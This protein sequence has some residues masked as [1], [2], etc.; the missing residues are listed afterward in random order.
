MAYERGRGNDEMAL[1]PL[2][3]PLNVGPERAIGQVRTGKEVVLL[4]R[5][6]SLLPGLLE[7]LSAE[8]EDVESQKQ[9]SSSRHRTIGSS[10]LSQSQDQS[11]GHGRTAGGGS[12][13][14]A[15]RGIMT[16]RF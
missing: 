8:Q 3:P 7:L 1:G 16:G 9:L 12:M 13:S 2:I 4:C 5:Q 14:E 11:F 15:K 10:G 6:N